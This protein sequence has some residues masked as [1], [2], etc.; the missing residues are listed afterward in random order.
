MGGNVLLRL[1]FVRLQSSG[2]DCLKVCG[3][4]G[5]RLNLRHSDTRWTWIVCSSSRDKVDKRGHGRMTGRIAALEVIFPFRRATEFVRLILGLVT[6]CA[7]PDLSYQKPP[8][9]LKKN[10]T[11]R[12]I[13]IGELQF[14]FA[15]RGLNGYLGHTCR[16]LLK[17]KN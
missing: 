13:I 4:S 10:P 8:S 12:S 7:A 16:E 17:P 11:A 9:G 1:V 3:R 14:F 6:V 2:K 5:S 15:Q